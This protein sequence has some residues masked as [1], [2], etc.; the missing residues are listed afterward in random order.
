[1]H[2][3]ILSPADL[4][5]VSREEE[6]TSYTGNMEI[7]CPSSLPRTRKLTKQTLKVPECCRLSHNRVSPTRIDAAA[8]SPQ[9]QTI[10]RSTSEPHPPKVYSVGSREISRDIL[11][12]P[13]AIRRRSSCHHQALREPALFCYQKKN[14]LLQCLHSRHIGVCSAHVTAAG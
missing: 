8:S 4:L 9:A 1:M 11:C 14:L 7:I 6:N 13:D 10:I 12:V 5:V 2:T 3:T